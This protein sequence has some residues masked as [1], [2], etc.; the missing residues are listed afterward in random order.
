MAAMPANANT[1]AASPFSHPSPER[2]HYAGHFMTGNPRI[3]DSWPE[4]FGDDRIT[5]AHTTCL[6]L[7]AHLSGA[8]IGNLQFDDFKTSSAAATWAA[9]MVA[10]AAAVVI[11]PPISCLLELMVS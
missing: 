10:T 5:V 3:G 9:F 8:W 11:N 4:A 7:D 6:N 2:I 1:L